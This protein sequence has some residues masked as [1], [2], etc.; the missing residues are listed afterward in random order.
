MAFLPTDFESLYTLQNMADVATKGHKLKVEQEEANI[1]LRNAYRQAAVNNNLA[2]NA[3]LHINQ[4]QALDLKKL[5]FDKNAIRMLSRKEQSRQRAV[6]A[7]MGGAF[8]RT[9]NSTAA[10]MQNIERRASL[11]LARKDLNRSI[12][13][14]SFDQRRVNVN[15]T[16]QSK[17]NVAFSNLSIEPSKTGAVLSMLGSGIQNNIDRKVGTLGSSKKATQTSTTGV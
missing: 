8:G 15:L 2:Y 17:N 1:K 12:R 10:V 4:E 14:A 13:M 16:T 7:S 3:L 5:A 6:N 9:G 11:A